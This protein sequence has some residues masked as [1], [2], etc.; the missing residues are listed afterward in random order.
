MR[1]LL[2]S[3]IFTAWALAPATARCDGLLY[4]LPKDGVSV[5]FDMEYSAERN[6]ME[7]T[8]KGSLTMSSVG[9]TTVQEQKCRWIEFTMV[10]KQGDRE[11]TN[12][13]K[14]LIPEKFLAEGQKPLEHMVKGWIRFGDREAQEFKGRDDSNAGPLP[15]FLS[16]PLKDQKK[17]EEQVVESKLGKL[18]CRGVTGRAESKQGKNDISF[19]FESRLHAKAPFG[20]VT[21]RIA[22]ERK[23]DGEVR[24]SGTI[25]LKLVEVRKDA[26]TKLPDNQ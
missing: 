10:M 19:T 8:S 11:R 12:T 9:Q 23:R 17:L 4:Q 16:G 14:V 7:R 20:V 18:K 13:A 6:G 15:A 5:R 26:T 25:T 3:M 22:Y 24:D 2:T 1:T 21:S